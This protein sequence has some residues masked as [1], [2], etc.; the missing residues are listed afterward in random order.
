[1][2]PLRVLVI[3][4]ERNIRVTLAICLEGLGCHVAQ[5][6]SGA[7]ALEA[8][9]LEP[10]DLAFCDLRL[11]AESGLDLLPRMQ[12]ERP[13]LE[14]VVITAYATI[15]TA[16]EAMRRGAR[17]YLPKPFTPAQIAHLVERARERRALE[18]RLS[19][20]EVRLGEAEPEVSLET[21]SARM[22]AVLEVIQRAAGHDVSVLLRGENGTGKGVLARLLHSRSRRCERPFVVVNCP[23]LS[24]ELLASELFGHAR[25]AFTGA[26]RDQEGRVEAAEGGTVFLDE[27]GEI[28][29]GLQ[30]KLLRF[31]QEKRFER[32]GENRTRTADVRIV[33]ATNRD[34]EAEVKAGRFREDL[35]Y[36]LNVVEITVPPLRE[37]VEDVLPL[38]R[39]FL[40]FFARQARRPAPELSPAAERVLAAYPWPGNVRE[41]RNAIERALILSPGQLLEP[42]SFPERIAALPTS[43]VLGGDFTAEETGAGRVVSPRLSGAGAGAGS[44]TGDPE[45]GRHRA[46]SPPRSG[47]E[48]WADDSPQRVPRLRR[49]VAG[50]L[51]RRVAARTSVAEG[52]TDKGL[53]GGRGRAV[54]ART[55]RLGQDRPTRG[56]RCAPGAA[57]PDGGRART[58]PPS[59]GTGSREAD[60][61]RGRRDRSRRRSRWSSDRRL[62]APPQAA[63]ELVHEG[64][65]E[66]L[67]RGEVVV[68]LAQ[69]A[70]VVDRRFP[71]QRLGADV[72]ELDPERGA[73]DPTGLE[74]P[75]ALP[76]VT[77]PDRRLH[78]GGHVVRLRGARRLPR[79]LHQPPPLR[80]PLED[81]VETDL[82]DVLDARPRVRMREGRPGG[83]KL[84]E[85]PLG[86]GHAEPPQVGGEREDRGSLPG[87]WG[88]RRGVRNF[89][90]DLFCWLNSRTCGGGR[91][92]VRGGG[93]LGSGGRRRQQSA[94]RRPRR[95]HDRPPRGRLVRPDL[96]R[97]RHR[98]R[99]RAV[100]EPGQHLDRVLDRHHLRELDDGRDAELT[101]SER[102]DHLRKSL[103]ELGR[104]LPVVGRPLREPELAV[105]EGEEARVTEVDPE[106]PAVEVGEGDEEVRHRVVLA[107]EEFGQAGGEIARVVRHHGED[108]RTRSRGLAG[109]THSPAGARTRTGVRDPTR[110]VFAC[111]TVGQAQRQH[112]SR[113]PPQPSP[114]LAQERVKRSLPVH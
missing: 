83:V 74:G 106:P 91:G 64:V 108:P 93:G 78:V 5:A 15:D 73:A 65:A 44:F 98:L 67:P 79:R 39:R 30:A 113:G 31:L 82:E 13:G 32:I 18:R 24:E 92:R 60:A 8:L 35:L 53:R 25:G 99:L 50:T 27:I 81:E 63:R 28:S 105:E 114:E 57:Q 66:R 17:D 11:G 54:P 72:V 37:R 96:R 107:A 26:V 111:S 87:N 47:G 45:R 102:L 86:D 42:E 33:A 40:A 103:D 70:H 104:H 19:E 90:I 38:V 36:R 34:L 7:A 62:A 2:I 69:A 76:A 55:D 46:P 101:L 1:M 22:H 9:R 23:T 100:E 80:V 10:F 43:P 58:R 4:D 61:A 6:S 29:P 89:G 21:A 49:H 112:P 52:R 12:A 75:L 95:C 59:S 56:P 48:G 3:D 88:P 41:L 71:A 77:L 51:S 110:P 84:V 68:G 16:V 20:L 97:D 109:R 14:V 94:R 85:E